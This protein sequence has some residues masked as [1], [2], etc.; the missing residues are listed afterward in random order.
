MFDNKL[1]IV[2]YK[3]LKRNLSKKKLPLK[4]SITYTFDIPIIHRFAQFR[5]TI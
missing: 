2:R 5:F 3:F 4:S 1:I